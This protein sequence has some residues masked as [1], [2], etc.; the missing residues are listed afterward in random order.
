MKMEIN[1]SECVCVW[2]G[3]EIQSKIILKVIKNKTEIFQIF[4]FVQAYQN[5]KWGG[6][7]I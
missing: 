1:I 2:G 6:E 5:R 4:L 7:K 3:G